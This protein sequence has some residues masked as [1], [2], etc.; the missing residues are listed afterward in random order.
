V[1]RKTGDIFESQAPLSA[2]LGI[3]ITPGGNSVVIAGF[4]DLTALPARPAK[5]TAFYAPDFTLSAKSPWYIPERC[6][7]LEAPS[8]GVP[9]PVPGELGFV[10]IDRAAVENEASAWLQRIERGELT[11][12][13]PVWFERSDWLPSDQE[14]SLLCMNAVSHAGVQLPYGLSGHEDGIVGV[15]PEVLFRVGVD[16]VITTMALAGTQRIDAGASASELLFDEKER[17][18]HRLVIEFIEEALRD[19]GDV[20]VGETTVRELPKL[21][22]LYTPIT[23]Y[24]RVAPEFEDLVRRL[25]PTPALGAVPRETGLRWLFE[26]EAAVPRG[27]HGAPFG[28]VLP[29][30]EMVCVV[31]IRNIQWGQNGSVIGAGC[32]IVAGSSPEGE[33]AE[34]CGKIASIRALLGLSS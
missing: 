23:V 6:E 26:R 31:A 7:L 29:S 11:K 18:E 1:E 14:R 17:R 30:G 9:I 2:F 27:R 16:G 4:G 25:H 10:P 3:P 13:V 19:L 12:I 20:V 15:T 34:A 32:G 21:R 8:I 33:Y 28:V 5:T 22:H 24:P